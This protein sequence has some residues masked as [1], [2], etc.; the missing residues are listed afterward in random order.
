MSNSPINAVRDEL[1]VF[2]H[3][4]TDRPVPAECSMRQ[5]K[6][7]Q[8]RNRNEKPQPSLD[9]MEGVS[10]EKRNGCRNVG[11]RQNT[12]AGKGYEK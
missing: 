8:R 2:S 10:C 7:D 4:E 9:R 3:I 6:H 5:V 1:M 12:K 11:E